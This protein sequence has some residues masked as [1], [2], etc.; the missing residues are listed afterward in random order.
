MPSSKQ[1]ASIMIPTDYLE[2]VR[3]ALIAEIHNDSKALEAAVRVL[4]ARLSRECGYGPINM[5]AVLDLAAALRPAATR[6]FSAPD[7]F[8]RRT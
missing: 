4:K 7:W 3:S 6:R 5:G 8:R 2:D 1:S